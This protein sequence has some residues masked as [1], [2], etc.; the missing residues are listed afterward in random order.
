MQFQTQYSTPMA[1][2]GTM[3]GRTPGMSAAGMD[4][5]GEITPPPVP[6]GA[7]V[8]AY[9]DPAA[10]RDASANAR[11]TPSGQLGPLSW[12]QNAAPAPMDL[13]HGL[14]ADVIESPT[15]LEEARLGSLKAMLAGMWAVTSL[16][17]S[18][19]ERRIWFPGRESCTTW[20]TIT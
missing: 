5:S 10:I 15:T 16:R 4:W 2:Q 14:P 9:D 17:R 19:W 11:T 1:G 3:P 13:R 18:W 12:S 7:S 8:V 20:A 6:Q